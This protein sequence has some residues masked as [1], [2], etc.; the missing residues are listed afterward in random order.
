M[1]E[2]GIYELDEK[3]STADSKLVETAPVAVVAPS[4][5]EV[6]SEPVTTIGSATAETVLQSPKPGLSL[7]IDCLVGKICVIV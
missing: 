4:E 6:T 2:F 3:E 1:N 7:D 5:K